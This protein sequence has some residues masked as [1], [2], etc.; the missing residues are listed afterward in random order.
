VIIDDH[1]IRSLILAQSESDYL[2][3]EVVKSSQFER[4]RSA[5]PTGSTIPRRR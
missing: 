1:A 4:A 5:S 3:D 2:A